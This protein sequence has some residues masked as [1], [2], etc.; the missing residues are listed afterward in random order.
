MISANI[1]KLACAGIRDRFSLFPTEL[2]RTSS[3][4]V[5]SQ[6]Y[7]P[8]PTKPV[9]GQIQEAANPKLSN[10][11]PECI[12]NEAFERKLVGWEEMLPLEKEA[13][14]EGKSN[15]AS[16]QWLGR[17]EFEIVDDQYTMR[18]RI[19]TLRFCGQT[20]GSDFNRYRQ[21]FNKCP[22]LLL[23]ATTGSEFELEPQQVGADVYCMSMT[24]S[25]I[26]LLLTRPS[27]DKFQENLKGDFPEFNDSQRA[28]IRA[29]LHSKQPLTAIHGPPGTGKTKV[30]AQIAA[31]LVE[32]NQKVLICAPTH[33]AAFNVLKYCYEMGLENYCQ[34]S[35]NVNTEF[36]RDL[37]KLIEDHPNA[38]QL[39]EHIANVNT[40]HREQPMRRTR[41]L[42]KKSSKIETETTKSIVGDTK[43]M[44]STVT[45]G[46]MI[47]LLGSF[48]PDV[49]IIDEAGQATEYATLSLML[50][51]PRLVVVGDHCQLPAVL[52][53]PRAAASGLGESLLQ[54]LSSSG[55]KEMIFPLCTQHRFNTAIQK[56]PNKNFY[57]GKLQAHPSVANSR[58]T[59]VYKL[60]AGSKGNVGKLIE[61][62]I[63][64]VDTDLCT[65][66][67]INTILKSYSVGSAQDLFAERVQNPSTYNIG[68]ALITARYLST[69]RAGLDE[70][71]VGCITP[72]RAQV[73]QIHS[74]MSKFFSEY[75]GKAESLDSNLQIS[76]VDGFQGQ[77][78]EAIVMSF[79]RNNPRQFIGFM[80]E[81]RRLNVA[82]TRAK[83]Q[84][85]MVGSRRML[86]S[87]E[88]L[89]DLVDVIREEGRIVH[90]MEVLGFL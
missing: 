55:K 63:A 18:G 10:L 28:A 88:M 17:Q 56:W 41:D 59:D 82:V 29:A 66:F 78:R 69:L 25:G 30:I 43:V 4:S 64:L 81:Y 45:S 51:S 86:E 9:G 70:S 31:N 6:N 67:D 62:P 72:Y 61:E 76:S 24:Q 48:N 15:D 7:A 52:H 68:E 8:L 89:G 2:I 54:H 13:Q 83:R 12:L 26:E 71:Q 49:V 46:H 34:V 84:F 22:L 80:S 39:R 36:T 38:P 23:P 11:R 40:V 75:S 60:K 19:L 20:N 50:Q 79:V 32:N 21:M 42:L 90:P 47:K 73:H 37:N 77:E 44:F 57:E 5:S 74:F 27:F 85:L 53:H 87:D 1:K 3:F 14:Y 65:E 35:G 33:K 58:I 16:A